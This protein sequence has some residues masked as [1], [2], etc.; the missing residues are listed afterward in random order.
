MLNQPDACL[1]EELPEEPTTL[2]TIPEIRRLVSADRGEEV[3]L[4]AIL[5][6]PEALSKV[7]RRVLRAA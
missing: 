4:R 3:G 5:Q 7:W 2:E 6:R 1:M